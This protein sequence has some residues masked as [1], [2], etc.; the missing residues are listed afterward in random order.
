MFLFHSAHTLTP[1]G[2]SISVIFT[3]T[4]M[5]APLVVLLTE[6]IEMLPVSLIDTEKPLLAKF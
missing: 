3:I 1:I 5:D 2:V 4:Q 6:A